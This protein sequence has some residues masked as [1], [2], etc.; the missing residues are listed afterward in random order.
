MIISLQCTCN[1][2]FYYSLTSLSLLPL[3]S[4][5]HSI[6]YIYTVPDPD[7]LS[8]SSN[9]ELYIR[10]DTGLL[11]KD[12]I[13]ILMNVS[14]EMEACS[15]NVMSCD[16]QLCNIQLPTARNYD[17]TRGTNRYNLFQ[18]T[19]FFATPTT[20]SVTQCEK[21]KGMNR[22]SEVQPTIDESSY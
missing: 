5:S 11:Y 2:H 18:E 7:R 20:A 15:S 10:P 8:Q 16:R 12:A 17:L 4:L 6:S 14:K 3:S 1:H 19:G 21:G 9:P 22:G 13:S